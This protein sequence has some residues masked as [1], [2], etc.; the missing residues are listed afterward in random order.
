MGV[1]LEEKIRNSVLKMLNLRCLRTE[2]MNLELRREVC[3]KLKVF[4]LLERIW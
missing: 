2:Y 1:Y 3:A 4:E